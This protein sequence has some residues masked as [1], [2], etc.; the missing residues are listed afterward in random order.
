M[1]VVHGGVGDVTGILAGVDVAKVVVAGLT[2]FQVGCEERG[3][4][5]GLRVGEEGLDLVGRD[6]VDGGKGEAKEAIA[7]VL[8]EFRADCFGRFDGLAGDGCTADV[9]GVSVDVTAG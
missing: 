8:S 6:G 1:G 4:E 7:L 3:V 5:A 9:D 2:L